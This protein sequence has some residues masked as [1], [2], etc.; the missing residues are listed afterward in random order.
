M[1][2]SE[3]CCEVAANFLMTRFIV[4]AQFRRKEDNRKSDTLKS[5]KYKN[6][7]EGNR[8]FFVALHQHNSCEQVR[9]F[10]RHTGNYKLGLMRQFVGIINFWEP[11]DA[12][13]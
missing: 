11:C 7:A 6:D 5:P 10:V 9:D 8:K 2:H 1:K 3:H 4:Y 13:R 12:F